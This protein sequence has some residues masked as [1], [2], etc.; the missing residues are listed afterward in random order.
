MV[1][2]IFVGCGAALEH[3]YRQPL[4]DM[5]RRGWLKV[6][7]VV[8]PDTERARRAAAWFRR[9]RSVPSL[10]AA[11]LA[12]G[13]TDLVIIASPPA[14]HASQTCVAFE[15]G[16]HVLCEKPM[17]H[18]VEGAKQMVAAAEKAGRLLALGMARRFYPSVEAV[19]LWVKANPDFPMLFSYREGSLFDWPVASPAL[20][21]RTTGGGGVLI[22]KGVHALDVLCHLFGAGRLVRSADDAPKGQ[23][24]E[25]NAVLD[26]AFGS[27]RGL[28]QVSWEAP[29]N[30]GFHI[31]GETEEL[32]MPI[33][34]IDAIWKRSS[35]P[36]SAWKKE[37]A[38][39]T[40]PGDLAEGRSSPMNIFD[41]IRLQLV[42][43]LRAI[44]L[45]EPLMAGG[46]E[47]LAVLGLLLAAY[48]QSTP[49]S[50]SWLPEAEQ[51]RAAGAHWRSNG[52]L[53]PS[54]LSCS[55]GA[56]PAQE[57]AP[58]RFH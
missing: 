47:G 21:R 12:V 35:S 27:S 33:S 37:E 38:R 50:Q 55:V 40:W 5:E 1:T 39:I 31:S 23:G 56:A 52:H 20:F 46:K 54:E 7:A 26:L 45:G 13:R 11:L 2:I 19:R 30:N 43:L 8:D 41:C 42:S 18:S 57:A 10:E 32:W 9:A 28:L 16:C 29:L 48:E 15:R 36:G 53:P 22:D 17:A 3:L 14:F 24:V 44:H 49:I 6:S 34:P 51:R 58:G 25:S 4:C